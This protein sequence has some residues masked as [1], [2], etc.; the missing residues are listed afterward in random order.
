MLHFEKALYTNPDQDL[1]VLWWDLVERYQ[2]IKR[3]EGRNVPDWASKIHIAAYPVYYHNYQL[4]HLL[5]A[6]LLHAIAKQS[7]VKTVNE[8]NFVNNPA[9]GNYLKDKVFKYGKKYRWDEMIKKATGEK[10]TARYF[11][12]QL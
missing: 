1:N 7:G 4:G 5:A 2:L 8:I 10:L 3:P 6:Q 11:V 9:I 12:E